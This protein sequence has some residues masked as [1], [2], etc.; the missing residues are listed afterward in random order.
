MHIL[1]ARGGE[2]QL[3]E[4]SFNK[5]DE[6]TRIY[7]AYKRTVFGIAFNYTRSDS[8]SNDILQI[9]GIYL[10]VSGFLCIIQRNLQL[11]N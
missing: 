6:F 1:K 3:N 9:F 7:H 4:Y 8:D 5:E 2:G 10:M 11:L